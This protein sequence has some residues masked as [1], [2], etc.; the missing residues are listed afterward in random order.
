[1]QFPFYKY[2]DSFHH[3][4]MFCSIKISRIYFLVIS[5][6]GKESWK[7]NVIMD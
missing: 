5:L 3:A 4:Q 7:V 1:M 2:T 6:E